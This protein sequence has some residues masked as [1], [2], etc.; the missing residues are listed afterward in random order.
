MDIVNE[1][2]QKAA[3]DAEK[4]KPITVE[5]H[6][7]VDLD[8]GN[9][10]AF[11]TNEV[12]VAKLRSNSEE[13]LKNLTRDNVQILL[14]KVWELPTRRVEE[15]VVVEL[16]KPSYIIPRSLPVPKPRE[17]TKWEKFAKE[18]GIVK[19]KKSKLQWDEVLKKWIPRFGY[20]KAAAEKEKDWVI[21]LKGNDDP[22]EDQ[23]EKK[24]KIKRENVAK[25]E[26][27]R[28]RNI[29]A[30]RKIKV[31]QAGMVSADRLSSKDLHKA[32]TIAKSSTASGG[33][34]QASLPKEKPARDVRNLMPIAPP[35]KKRKAI[36]T[37][38]DEKKTTIN[39]IDK[40]LNKTPRLDIEAAVNRELFNQDSERAEEKRSQKP[41][42]GRGGKKKGGTT[43]GKKGRGAGKPQVARGGKAKGGKD[44]KGGKGGKQAGRGKGKRR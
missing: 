34:F 31:P 16:P 15:C 25:N 3:R 21:E 44:A 40:I 29:A 18:K 14:N 37:P 42:A 10:L 17:P 23:F 2:L 38:A 6:L 5:K 32:A 19:T 20:K 9:L 24:K 1:V 39:I 30:A 28:M 12:E 11:D 43:G 7:E 41:K 35:P 26:L 8:P 13:Y 36:I 33:K 27:Q 22:M 4:F